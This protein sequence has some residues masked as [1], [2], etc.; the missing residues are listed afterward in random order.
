MSMTFHEL[1]IVAG[2]ILH[3]AIFTVLTLIFFVTWRSPSKNRLTK[4][5]YNMYAPRRPLEIPIAGRPKILVTAL[6]LLA[7]TL[8]S[9]L[10][11]LGGS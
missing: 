3:I 1:L 4:T 7:V 10:F 5:L 11:G 8:L 9:L 6:L 2:K